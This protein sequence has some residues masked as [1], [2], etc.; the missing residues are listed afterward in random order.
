MNYSVLSGAVGKLEASVHGFTHKAADES[1]V[2][3]KVSE[4]P[5]I[6]SDETSGGQFSIVREIIV[7]GGACVS[8]AFESGR[9]YD[10]PVIKIKS[11]H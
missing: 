9:T 8:A 7:H 2:Y 10:V 5:A 4:Q 11:I 1:A 6:V 3:K